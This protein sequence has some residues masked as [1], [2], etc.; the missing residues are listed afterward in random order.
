MSNWRGTPKSGGT[1][2]AAST[3]S[4]VRAC[5]VVWKR[6]EARD[7]Q[8]SRVE[9]SEAGAPPPTPPPLLAPP[10]PPSPAA[11]PGPSTPAE[12][13]PLVSAL[14]A[15]PPLL[16]STE[17]AASG[18]KAAIAPTAERSIRTMRRPRGRGSAAPNSASTC[19]DRSGATS[20]ND[21]ATARPM[22]R[23]S[24]G[25]A[26]VSPTGAPSAAG[27]PSGLAARES[28]EEAPSG[29]NAGATG[30]SNAP[31]TAVGL[32]R[33][34]NNR[35]SAST[36]EARSRSTPSSAVIAV[37]AAPAPPRGPEAGRERE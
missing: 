8:D 35:R 3:L 9:A 33:L 37:A 22:A 28:A 10:S 27:S 16:S 5:S 21:E 11:A 23:A 30:P 32:N 2:V 20:S 4:A 26:S 17:S 13:L 12:V 36:A 6:S 7:A 24:S 29:R 19:D 18:R 34:S 31:A 15:K 1:Q 14:R 25:D